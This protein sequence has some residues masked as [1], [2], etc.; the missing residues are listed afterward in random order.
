[1]EHLGIKRV[2]CKWLKSGFVFLHNLHGMKGSTEA[3]KA[4]L[5]FGQQHVSCGCW[6]PVPNETSL[7][8]FC[9][10]PRIHL[11]TSATEPSAK[12]SGSTDHSHIGTTRT[13]VDTETNRLICIVIN[14]AVLDWRWICSHMN[15]ACRTFRDYCWPAGSFFVGKN[16]AMGRYSLSG[17]GLRRVTWQQWPSKESKV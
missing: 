15:N 13:A 12:H 7:Y 6:V 1:M 3:N 11:D 5:F 4:H 10:T 16:I 8:A 17:L 9:Q 2:C 14:T